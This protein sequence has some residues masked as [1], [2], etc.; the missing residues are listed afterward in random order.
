MTCVFLGLESRCKTNN[1][2][3][4]LPIFVITSNKPSKFNVVAHAKYNSWGKFKGLPKRFAMQKYC[5]VVYHFANG[6]DSAFNNNNSNNSSS[7]NN[8]NSDIVYDDDDDDSHGDI[9]EDGYPNNTNGGDEYSEAA[10]IPG[11]MGHRPS[12]L[13]G[14]EIEGKPSQD[15]GYSSSIATSVR[16]RNAA[17]AN[18]VAALQKA[19]QD[20]CDIDAADDDG[21]TA[22]HFAADRKSLDCLLILVDAGANV[23]AVDC[24]GFGVLQ[25]A[26]SSGLGVESIRILL[27]AGAD[28]DACDEDGESP[29]S[30]VSEEGNVELIDL[31][32]V[33]PA[34]T[35]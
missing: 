24:D 34:T 21:Q 3:L 20:G 27:E 6:G 13:S 12:T 5:E 9:D 14:G 32:A 16:L 30:W 31:F 15:G 22:L 18:D 4:T 1:F 19:I 11:G 25:I 2:Q 7:T 33:F 28:P 35:D 17:I 23:N 29:R 8:D 10:G 26:L